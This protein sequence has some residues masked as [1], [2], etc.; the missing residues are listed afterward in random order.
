MEKTTQE[1]L[2]EVENKKNVLEE[3]IKNDQQT[4]L[5]IQENFEIDLTN[6]KELQDMELSLRQKLYD[7]QKNSLHQSLNAQ[8]M[9]K[10]LGSAAPFFAK[11][12]AN[13]ISKAKGIK[14]YIDG[15]YIDKVWLEEK[16]SAYK[17]VCIE[18]GDEIQSKEEFQKIAL[19]IKNVQDEIK[20]LSL[21]EI[22]T[23]V[24][25]EVG[26]AKKSIS[27]VM[28]NMKIEEKFDNF[29]KKKKSVEKEENSNYS[30]ME[31]NKNSTLAMWITEKNPDLNG[32]S[33]DLYEMY[34]SYINLKFSKHVDDLDKICYSK[35]SGSFTQ[36]IN[37]YLAKQK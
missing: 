11:I 14:D 12:K 21:N 9:K 20:E 27:S 4:L 19:S 32:N 22:I 25:K 13:T 29:L 16:Y 2:K 36:A 30:H 28:E 6:L 23:K 33:A 34:I 31:I 26:H 37:R 1:L 17:K 10:I 3:K 5:K 8:S 24:S 7:Q 35:K 15:N 18:K